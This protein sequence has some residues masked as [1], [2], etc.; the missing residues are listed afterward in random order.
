MFKH[1]LMA[2]A[3]VLLLM[4][5]AHAANLHTC[6]LSPDRKSVTVMVSNPY[7]Q[8]TSCTVNCHIAIP[9]SGVA[10][11]SCT[12]E[13]PA[14]AKD[15]VLCTRTRDNN[16]QY[17][18]L[19]DAGNSECVKPL[20]AEKDSKEADDDDDKLAQEML[21]KSQDMLKSLQKK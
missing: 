17:V 9:G 19:D 16:A 2:A 5:A 12:K 21:K 13:V 11:I 10:S 7:A 15:Y 1:S 8:D 20:A 3:L 14:N 4:P 18:K 6:K